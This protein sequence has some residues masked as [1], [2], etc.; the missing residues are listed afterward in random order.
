MRERAGRGTTPIT[1]SSSTP[2][3]TYAEL[4]RDDVVIGF[5]DSDMYFTTPV[6]YEDLFVRNGENGGQWIAKNFGMNMRVMSW[7]VHPGVALMGAET[8]AYG[9]RQNYRIANATVA[10]RY[11]R[12]RSGSSALQ[13]A[14]ER[15]ARQRPRR[16][17]PQ[18]AAGPDPADEDDDD[19]REHDQDAQQGPH[20]PSAEE[21]ETA[22]DPSTEEA[23]TLAGLEETAPPPTLAGLEE[24]A[25]THPPT[26]AG[27]FNLFETSFPFLVFLKD[28]SFVREVL[29]A[30]W[31]RMELEM[32]QNFLVRAPLGWER[33]ALRRPRKDWPLERDT[34]EV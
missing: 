6:H 24:T 2:E 12:R 10:A 3:P 5:L 20:D 27:E 21:L 26:L 22:H 31:A 16:R 32:R 4:L 34:S 18:K 14:S 15:A 13:R 30:R 9:P 7:D 33:S 8:H 25:S 1:L 23:K 28:L 19:D 29:R 11:R 17:A